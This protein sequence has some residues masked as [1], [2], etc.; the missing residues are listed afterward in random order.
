MSGAEPD[1]DGNAGGGA[2][3]S[4]LGLPTPQIA[5]NAFGTFGGVFTPS[6]LTI[7]GV[8]MFMR[9]GYVT[10]QA[11]ILSAMVILFVAK[12]ITLLTSLSISGISTNTRVRGG[13]AYF[14]IS[15]SMGAEFG[16][17]IGLALFLAQALSVP[18][19]IL[20]FVEALVLVFPGLQA[21]FLLIGFTI[22]CLL[23]GITYVGADWA[24]KAQYFI[25]TVLVLSVVA[26]L[27]G[28]IVHF[29]SATFAANWEPGYTSPDI[30][31]WVIFA[32][33]FPAVTGIMAG[34]NMSGDLADPARS[35]P[36]GTLAAV[37]VGAVI[38]L[39]QILL[40]GGAQTRPM[41][42]DAPY[43]SLLDQA[44]FGLDF[45]IVAGVFAATLSS[46]LGSLLGAPRILQALA[47]DHIFPVLRIFAHGLPQTDEPRRGSWLTFAMTLIV[48]FL[49]GGE[50]GG[51][52]LNSVAVVLTMFFLFTYG[53]VNIAAFVEKFGQNP[54]FR[55]RFKYF[56]WITAL[57]GAIGCVAATL[58]I[59]PGAAVVSS[60]LIAAVFVYV[61]R[62]VLTTSFGDSRRGFFYSRARANLLALAAHPA[63]PKNWRPTTLVL[64]GNPVHRLTLTTY[65][66][67]F[68]SNR[69]IV[70]LSQILIGDWYARV[71]DRNASLE[72]LQKW[73]ERENF[74]AFAEAIVAKD[75]E[76]GIASLLQ[77]HSIGPLK[78]NL[79]VLGWSADP[80][81]A[82]T[83]SRHL[84]Y[85]RKLGMSEV[86]V[87]DRGLPEES[88]DSSKRRI[89]I[90]WRGQ[91][92]GSLMIIL[93]YLLTLNH[94]WQLATIRVLRLVADD[95]ER[96]A[97][98]AE[99]EELTEA[100][101][102]DV[103][104]KIVVGGGI[105]DALVRHSAD[106]DVLM[107]G[108]EPTDD[109]EQSER[110]HRST[111][112][113]LDGLPTALLVTSSGRRRRHG[114]SRRLGAD[115]QPPRK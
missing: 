115:N 52:A 78:P 9:T 87:F 79:V 19:Y 71:E 74:D 60:I 89:D 26:L 48:L 92:N 25:L 23:F 8:I 80:A 97:A 18:F 76:S 75:V 30:D 50:A 98:L 112:A 67:L 70:T 99:I 21:Y 5:G 1:V 57:L 65:A 111:T 7:L 104:S 55:P 56:H 73:I 95:T 109:E 53:M 58:L 88:A 110:F 86:I 40:T 17:S 16:G 93:A 64:S 22:A 77:A 31:F 11:G 43:E 113:L 38:Y 49:A 46:A 6:I 45:L 72:S 66:L 103:K 59:N 82:F 35:I 13:G 36:R 90:W 114:L 3:G 94:G 47:R 100:A 14:L 4:P 101:R 61:R 108:F 24:I 20:G 63:H 83:F 85:I 69:G 107:L 51:G 29:D 81:R 12:G 34:V 15:R 33:F 68:A 84:S 44:L 2:E 10:G 27:A 102:I 106:A 96:D 37:G 105:R 39:A 28:A 91:R 62:R 41:L 54:S 32:I 42:V